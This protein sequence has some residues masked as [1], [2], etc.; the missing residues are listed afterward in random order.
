[1]VNPS[2]ATKVLKTEIYSW[3]TYSYTISKKVGPVK[4]AHTT[5]KTITISTCTYVAKLMKKS[6]VIKSFKNRPKTKKP[7]DTL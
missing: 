5:P 4:V 1:M 6:G 3:L 7:V 2:F